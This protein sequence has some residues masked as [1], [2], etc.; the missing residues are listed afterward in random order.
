[1]QVAAYC[2][3]K[4]RN[5]VEQAIGA[6]AEFHEKWPAFAEDVRWADSAVAVLEWLAESPGAPELH[7]LR[8][9][10]P[11]THVVLVTRME[12][13]N[14]ILAPNLADAVVWI[15]HARAGLAKAVR[16]P[17]DSLR[18]RMARFIRQGLEVS[19]RTKAALLEAAN[20]DPPIRTVAALAR[21]A[22]TT[23]RTLE[24]WFARD[25]ASGI[26]PGVFLD[27]MVLLWAMDAFPD[28]SS[29]WAALGNHADA[30]PQMLKETALRLIGACP[31]AVAAR[32]LRQTRRGRKLSP[33][34][35]ARTILAEGLA[36][37][38]RP[39]W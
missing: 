10:H 38:L 28:A 18:I 6:P 22:S 13:E 33:A 27:A 26:T 3:P 20:T 2:P 32:L 39:R 4:F 21:A 17:W 29:S 34:M 31:G 15:R 24:R 12:G 14:A 1:M 19:K 36:A 37:L 9:A 11:W 16:A 30:D 25:F 8:N 5:L 35:I 23:V 7:A